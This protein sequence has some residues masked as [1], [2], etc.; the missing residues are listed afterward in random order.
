ME[1]QAGFVPCQWVGMTRDNRKDKK[2]KSIVITEIFSKASALLKL[3]RESQVMLT[4]A[5]K[6]EVPFVLFS[7]GMCSYTS[8][9]YNFHK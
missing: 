9:K 2:Q 5:E 7:L 3:T 6:R 4:P 8:F 1:I